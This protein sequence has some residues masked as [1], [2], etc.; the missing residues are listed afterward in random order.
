MMSL[1]KYNSIPETYLISFP[2]TV[3]E[4][5]CIILNLHVCAYVWETENKAGCQ[6]LLE[7]NP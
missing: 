3:E 5:V 2:L 6:K 7:K 1:K 4:T